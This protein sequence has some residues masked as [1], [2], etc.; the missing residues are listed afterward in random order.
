MT[1][2]NI[3]SVQ[4]M[5]APVGKIFYIDYVYDSPI[6]NAVNRFRSNIALNWPLEAWKSF[7]DIRDFS[8]P[9]ISEELL[10]TCIDGYI[11]YT[12]IVIYDT[13]A[14]KFNT[15]F[16]E[17]KNLI[18]EK[19]PTIFSNTNINKDHILCGLHLGYITEILNNTL[20]SLFLLEDNFI[21]EMNDRLKVD[22]LLKIETQLNN[23]LF[24]KC[25]NSENVNP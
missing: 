23:K 25:R 15:L 9:F 4:P 24:E 10:G 20:F 2:N 11:Y 1:I 3:I 13:E 16:E 19:L 22:T 18:H 21:K 7:L 14:K 5:T 8:H 6:S 17:I 12:D